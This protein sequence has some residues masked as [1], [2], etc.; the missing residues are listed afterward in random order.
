MT[1]NII[2][3]AAGLAEFTSNPKSFFNCPDL[4]GGSGLPRSY[5]PARFPQTESPA[6]LDRF[7][8]R[9]DLAASRR[10]VRSLRTAAA[11][12]DL[13]NGSIYNRVQ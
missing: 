6:S 3:R 7:G 9:G 11:T 4:H 10:K 13:L 5:A 8:R 2:S 1:S 12:T